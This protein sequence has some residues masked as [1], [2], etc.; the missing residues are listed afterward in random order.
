MKLDFG[1]TWDEK[2]A[3]LG[4][5]HRYFAWYPVKINDHDYR[6]L[7]FVW[8]KGNYSNINILWYWEYRS[9]QNEP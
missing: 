3:R 2:K 6:W 9:L 7:E 8:R 5:W 4:N 1:E